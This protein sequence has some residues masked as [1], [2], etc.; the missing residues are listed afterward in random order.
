MCA[1]S[2]SSRYECIWTERDSHESAANHVIH[3]I[4]PAHINFLFQQP[5]AFGPFNLNSSIKD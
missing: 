5:R 4:I 3:I 2:F 1:M